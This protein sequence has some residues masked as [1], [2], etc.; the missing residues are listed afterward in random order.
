MEAGE[1]DELELVAHLAELFLEGRDLRVGELLLPVERGGAVVGED[2]AGE[3]LVD[4]LGEG[5]GLADVGRG[6]LAPDDVD[7]RR[8]GAGAGDGVVEASLDDEEAVGRPLAGQELLVD[9][10]DV[11]ADEARAE[12][13][14]PADE[15]RRDAEDVGRE[16]RGDELAG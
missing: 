11:A 8:V 9:L 13:V 3:L 10:V 6:G 16:A 14:G 1:R 4:A 12:G 2:L 7:V 5:A 15:D